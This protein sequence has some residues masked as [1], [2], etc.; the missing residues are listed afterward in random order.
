MQ[1]S[2]QSDQDRGL[3]LWHNQHLTILER[4]ADCDVRYSTERWEQ[5]SGDILFC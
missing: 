3:Q 5:Y 4:S 2:I 1:T